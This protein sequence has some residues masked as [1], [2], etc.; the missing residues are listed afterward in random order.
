M[1]AAGTGIAPMR[2]FLLERAALKRASIVDF[3][4][5]LLFSGC[6][7]PNKDFLYSAE[8]AVWEKEG[9]VEVRLP[10]IPCGAQIANV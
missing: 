5:M 2:A 3:G 9:I 6:R 4:P 1:Q 7:H 10:C 8:M